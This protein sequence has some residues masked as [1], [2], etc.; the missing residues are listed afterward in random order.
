MSNWIIP[1]DGN[2]ATIC[3]FKKEAVIKIEIPVPKTIEVTYKGKTNS[4]I[5]DRYE[6]SLD[7]PPGGQ[8]SG[9]SYKLKG[10]V[11]WKYTNGLNSYTEDGFILVSRLARGPISSFRVEPPNPENRDVNGGLFVIVTWKDYEEVSSYVEWIRLASD[12]FNRTRLTHNGSFGIKILNFN[13][14]HWERFDGTSLEDDIAEYGG[15]AKY[16]LK[17]Y[18]CNDNLT[19]T[20]NYNEKPK[21][22]TKDK[23]YFPPVYEKID[24]YYVRFVQIRKTQK[25]TSEGIKLCRIIEVA[26]PLLTFSA[27]QS[28]FSDSPFNFVAEYCSPL[29]SDVYPK[30]SYMC[31]CMERCPPQTVC[32]IQQ[33]NKICCLDK[34]GN[35]IKQ[36]DPGCFE[37]DIKC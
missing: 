22:V 37:P 20:L 6:L 12:G 2:T 5:A 23:G 19:E 9:K 30:I 36:I 24:L 1:E 17:L 4:Y 32:S 33:G 26:N 21:I 11:T 10:I 29:C 14:T 15:Q 13:F 3:P 28:P 35:V 18:D 7:K 27:S 16:V 25:E 8:G 31:D 34:D